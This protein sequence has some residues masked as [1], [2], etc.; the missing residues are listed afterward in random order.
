M[1]TVTVTGSGTP[2]VV[3]GRAGPGVLVVHDGAVLQFD[4]G[5]ATALRL[6]EA[7]VRLVDLDA[8]F[9]THHHSDH[10]VGLADLLM[11][12]WLEAS[13]NTR[14]DLLPVIV[15]DGP[16]A[17]LVEHLLDPWGEE[18]AMRDAHI[19]YASAPDPDVRT[20]TAGPAPHTVWQSGPVTVEAVAVRH[21]PVEPAVGYRVTTPDGVV[22]ISGDT[23]VCSEIEELAGGA[24]VL[25]HEAF[26]TSAVAALLSDPEAIGAYHSDTIALG[27][28]A[29]RARVVTLVLTHLIPP[30]ATKAD[31]QGF[32]DDVRAGGYRGEIVVAGDLDSITVAA[33]SPPSG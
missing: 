20:F 19:G 1:T 13:R 29:A 17:R 4:C 26:R 24:D 16:G 27:G 30:P 28:L 14:L 22:V 21:E 2:I 18:L 11:S 8:V 12:R 33:P 25:V 6:A 32:I 5:R 23:A 15:P 7:G 31:E 3:P 10:V 9:I